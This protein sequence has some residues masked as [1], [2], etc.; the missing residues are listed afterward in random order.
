VNIDELRTKLSSHEV[1]TMAL[2]DGT[3]VLVNLSGME[4]LTFN[5]TGMF[6]CQRVAGGAP[7]VEALAS[8]LVEE[9][10]VDR[11]TAMA[12]AT[13]FLQELASALGG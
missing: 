10:E 6:L 3:G 1:T 7:D 2:R 5:E 12:S 13:A 9:F 8:A 11:A 4:V